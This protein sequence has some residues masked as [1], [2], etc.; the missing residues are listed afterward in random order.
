[1]GKVNHPIKVG[2]PQDYQTYALRQ[3]IATHTRK[4]TCAEASCE[5]YEKGWT[6]PVAMLSE[7]DLHVATHAGKKF[8]R[9]RGEDFGVEPGEYL[10]F[11]PGQAC[12][13][14]HTHR[15][16]VDRE[17]FTYIGRGDHRLFNTR[18][19]VRMKNEDWRD[20]MANHLDNIKTL[21]EMG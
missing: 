4:A 16:P 6:L 5:S 19:S 1:M 13:M 3:P 18:Q 20:H 9:V 21:R 12:F 8:K 11:E 2:R 7:R 17:P 14:V 10:V 15:V